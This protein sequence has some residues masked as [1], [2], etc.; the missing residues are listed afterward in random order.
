MKLLIQYAAEQEL[1]KQE[2]INWWRKFYCAY[3]FAV[4][5]TTF[6]LLFCFLDV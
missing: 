4:M 1:I 2:W 3:L 5:F 6:V